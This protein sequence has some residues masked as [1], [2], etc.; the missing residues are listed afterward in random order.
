MSSK[1]SSAIYVRSFIFGVE[2]SL[3][4][5]VG[6][7]AGIASA[8][9][10]QATI[11]LTGVVLI[12]VEAFSMAVGTFLSERSAEEF[13]E[14]HDLPIRYPLIGSTIM[15]FSYL[16]SGL[17]PLGPYIR[18]SG[19]DAFWISII[20][21]LMSLFLVGAISAR[22]FRVNWAWSGIRMFFIGG[23]AV[24]VGVTVGRLIK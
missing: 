3:S 14:H 7:L 24:A 19:D 4:S 22:Y 18:Y 20:A 21:T 2:D 13:V 9:A 1:Q 16:I 6:L 15:F 11:I 12:A 10:E 5:T 8:G 17:I 23:L